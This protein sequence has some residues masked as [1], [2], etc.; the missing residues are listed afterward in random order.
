MSRRATTKMISATSVICTPEIVMIWKMP[1]SRIR[2]RASLERKSR[3]PVTIAAAIAPSSPPM[4][5]FTLSAR[6]LRA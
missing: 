2:S 1:A 3:F 4:I 5:A 6:R